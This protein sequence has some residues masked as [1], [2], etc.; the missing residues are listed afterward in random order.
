MTAPTRTTAPAHLAALRADA[1]QG[2]TATPKTLPPKWLYDE[3]GSK[4]FEQITRLPEYF[5]TRIERA[6]L[7]KVGADIAA[8]TGARS[9]VE[10][11]AGGSSKS[12]AILDA[13]A[14]TV[15][16]YVPVDVSRSALEQAAPSLAAAYPGVSIRPQVAD[17]TAPLNLEEVG[18]PRLTMFLGGTLGNLLPAERAEFFASF[19]AQLAPHDHLLLG[20]HLVTDPQVIRAAYDDAAGITARFNFGILRRLNRELGAD[21][22]VDAF[23]HIAHWDTANEAIEM[24]LRSRHM[25]TVTLRDPGLTIHF[26]AGEDLRTEVSA[27]FRPE[28]LAREL[29]AAGLELSEFWTDRDRL[30]GL[31]LIAPAPVS[32]PAA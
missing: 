16:T 25:Q 32:S 14:A 3:A 18:G 7:Y 1:V 26:S 27:K 24:R 31:A 20:V 19:A 30:I 13:L 5:Q 22:D 12:R 10:L 15:T 2:L 8:I 6:L 9:L 29:R 23:E 21:F 17:F 28:R 11:G 4:L